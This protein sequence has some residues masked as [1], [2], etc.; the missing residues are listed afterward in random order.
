MLP[1][2]PLIKRNLELNKCE[3][4]QVVS[5]AVGDADG[6]NISYTPHPFSFVNKITGLNTDP[7]R[8][9]LTAIT[10]SLNEHF[11]QDSVLPNFL[12]IDV[13][14]AEM[15]VLRGMS[16]LLG[17][18]D[19]QMLLEVHAHHLPRFGSSAG[20]VLDF[21]YERGFRTYLLGRF[22][23]GTSDGVLREIRDAS[24]VTTKSGDMLL[25][26]RTALSG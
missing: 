17:Q 6:A 12:K 15:A 25:V 26:T 9:Q 2:A 8:M 5:A 23:N 1:F 14:G 18:P 20:A 11:A 13:D 22:R 24:E 7:F 21:L 19:L 4:V 16:R 10:V 3:N